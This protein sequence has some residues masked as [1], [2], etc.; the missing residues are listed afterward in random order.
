LCNL[1]LTEGKAFLLLKPLVI[2]FKWCMELL[3]PGECPEFHFL[4]RQHEFNHLIA[5][6]HRKK[7]SELIKKTGGFSL[8]PDDYND[9][10]HHE[11]LDSMIRYLDSVGRVEYDFLG[12]ERVRGIMAT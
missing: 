6:N 12:A 5:N 11:V 7:R 4:S 3:F 10:N 1:I 2:V 9:V 8:G